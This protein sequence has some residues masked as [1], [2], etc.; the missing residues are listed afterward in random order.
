[1]RVINSI[2]GLNGLAMLAACG[3]KRGVKVDDPPVSNTAELEASLAADGRPAEGFYRAVDETGLVLIEEL[4][5]DGTY[6]F[7][8][9]DGELIEEGTYVQKTPQLP[10]F[11]PKAERAVEK[12]YMDEVGEDGVWR[13]T[14]PDTGIVS[15]IERI[16]QL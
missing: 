5:S 15:V 11:T 12:C 4:R 13:T 1:M 8:D 14:D 16:E 9:A 6:V 3:A 10:C 2:I 7:T